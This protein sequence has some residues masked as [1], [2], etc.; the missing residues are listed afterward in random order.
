MY[1]TEGFQV[2]GATYTPEP[3]LGPAQT[4]ANFW[5]IVNQT[6]AGVPITPAPLVTS[7]GSTGSAGSRGSAGS[8]R[9]GSSS[10]STFE[11]ARYANVPGGILSLVTNPGETDT[12][13]MIYPKYISMYA[14]AKYDYNPVAAR[15]ALINQFD[16]LQNELQT[17]VDTEG[18]RRGLYSGSTT[19]LNAKQDSCNQLNMLTMAYYGQLLSV[20]AL[21]ADLSGAAI[22]AG[23]MHE[24]NQGL[25]NSVTTACT[26]QGGT[27]SAA[28]IALASMDEK[29][30]PLLSQFTSMNT[31]LIDNAENIQQVINV[32]LRAYSGM[33]CRVP[34]GTG[35]YDSSMPSIDTVFSS[36][37]L[38]SVQVADTYT[39]K[40]Q[41][42]ELSPYYVSPN[43]INFI[44]QGITGITSLSSQGSQLSTGEG[45][46]FD[47]I[48]D[49]SRVTN[50]IVSLNSD[51]MP[52]EAGKAYSEKGA[53]MGGFV[54]CPPGYT[55]PLTSPLPVKC[56]V[57]FYCPAGT[58]GNPIK[59]PAGLYSSAGASDESQCTP[60]WPLGYYV[61]SITGSLNRCST[62]HY[63]ANGAITKCPVGTYNKKQGMSSVS[64]CLDCPKGAYCN[65]TTTITPCAP[66]TYNGLARQS[67][68]YKCLT[69][70]AGT[71]CSKKG[72]ASPSPCPPGSW[73]SVE[74]LKT[75]CTPSDTGTY[76]D[77]E[78]SKDRSAQK[79]CTVGSFCPPGSGSPTACPAGYYCDRQG[80]SE[81][82]KCPAGTYGS[83]L[84][85]STAQCSGQCDPGYACPPGSTISYNIPC[86]A[87]TYCPRGTGTP[88]TCPK[89]HYC[90][91]ECG[92][93][94]K[95]PAGTYNQ[96]DGGKAVT[97]CIICPDGKECVAG[98]YDPQPCS[99]G[100]FCV[101]GM[102]NVCTPG[103]YCDAR[104]LASPTG[105]PPGT[106]GTKTGSTSILDCTPCPAGTFSNLSGQQICAGSCTTGKICPSP[107]STISYVVPPTASY[108]G[109]ASTL[110]ITIGST[111]P[112]PC[113]MGYYCDQ[114]NMGIASPCPTG[115]YSPNTGL[116]S[117]SQCTKC[118]AGTYC[119]TPGAGSSLPCPPGTYCPSQGGSSPTQCPIAFICPLPGLTAG[120]SCPPGK[121]C[122]IQGLGSTARASCPP[123]TYSVGGA[124]M[125][126]TPCPDGTY[127]TGASTNPSCSGLCAAGYYCTAS[128]TTPT[129]TLCP[130]GYYCPP[131]TGS[132]MINS[133]T[134]QSVSLSVPFV[135]RAGQ[136]FTA[137]TVGSSNDT[138]N[139]WSLNGIAQASCTKGTP[140]TDPSCVF[141]APTTLGI[142]AVRKTLGAITL[143]A[144]VLVIP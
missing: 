47:Y 44:S 99:K 5:A 102:V 83:T 39:L 23:S 37:Y 20:Y 110:T 55:C 29:L 57:G 59:C 88:N 97:D 71:T 22:T 87:G 34:T 103:S 24:E 121:L 41:L 137:T 92:T 31:N 50:S 118:P 136:Q 141:T 1:K 2:S 123:G 36:E 135:V 101:G 68:Y 134:N 7:A 98:T 72:M 14:L 65:N 89:G 122:D 19:A 6:K 60:N 109:G 120:G 104:G 140:M 51:G 131:G 115:T 133:V 49:M 95:C 58:T 52:A 13:T 40:T 80:L 70:P 81:G 28:C 112:T 117:S 16:V 38:S 26:N 107:N 91:Y 18:Q 114:S 15:S 132:L 32:L 84:G 46:S 128:S 126:C 74:G 17:A 124:G 10:G 33:A 63:C 4:L 27:P 94:V 8:S 127:G 144:N 119:A 48:A 106:Y 30:F 143:S 129:T 86:V 42:Q 90:P 73:S 12:F 66:G 61:D 82:T 64:S 79:Q 130:I 45:E 111:E 54:N 85:L 21:T 138:G 105:C 100:N 75:A 25:Q 53:G 125:T 67:E 142:L 76:L 96:Y 9:P 108:S 56:P 77:V 113:P 116:T 3:S 139:N 78:G 69:C 43:I 11:L 93:P 62:G 35:S